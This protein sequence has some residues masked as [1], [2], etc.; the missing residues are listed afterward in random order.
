MAEDEEDFQER[1][2]FVYKEMDKN[3]TGV[4]YML[5]LRWA[6]SRTCEGMSSNAAMMQQLVQTPGKGGRGR[7]VLNGDAKSFQG[8]VCQVWR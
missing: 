4:S 2:E 8:C 7:V 3:K 6:R 1:V 5:F